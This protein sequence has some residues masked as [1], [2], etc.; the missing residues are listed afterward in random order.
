MPA[1][2]HKSRSGK[3]PWFYMFS[4][5]GGTRKD[6]K[7]VSQSGFATKREA[8]DAEASRRIEEQKKLEMVR[9]GAIVAGRV[10]TTLSELLDEFFTHHVDENLAPKTAERYHDQSKYLDAE[11]LQMSIDKITPLHL[12]REWK[13]LLKSGG[14][15]RKTKESRPLS[16][17]TVRNVA[18]IVSSAFSRA[19]R[20]GL[21]TVNPVSFSEPPIPK[22]SRGIALTTAQQETI[23]AAATGPWC[24]G[25]FLEVSAGTGARR[26][27]ILALRWS[28]IKS[29]RAVIVQSLS[30]TR[31][32][33]AFKSTKTEDSVR[34]VSLPASTIS[35]L[36]SHRQRQEVFR[37]QFGR[38]Y[39]T[40][41]D[42]IFANPDGT[43]LKPDSV[44]ATISA[45]CR[46][47]KLPKGASL[48]TLRH[49]HGS[50]LIASG[51]DLATVSARLGHSSVRV[52]AEIY[53]HM[54]PG[55]D[56]EAAIKWDEFQRQNSPNKSLGGAP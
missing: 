56:D 21:V 4:L 11:L 26:G 55:R 13:R 28:D 44:S 53:T 50:H 23:I 36:E 41:L 19:I 30:Q 27:E 3:T 31:Q 54:I 42:L 5:P 25:T 14:H 16:A 18:G 51:M 39:R 24:L 2:K 6:R 22:K 49:T 52:T 17:K 32:S 10:P 12:G 7:R 34:P 38:D 43:P 47:L 35:A 8:E 15:H 37:Q 45:L 1:Y 40:D 9:A 33:L 48:H 29:A 46:R 20:W